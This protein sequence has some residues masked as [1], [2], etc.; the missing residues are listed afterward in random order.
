[1]TNATAPELTSLDKYD[2][3]GF[4]T[5]PGPAVLL[6]VSGEPPAEI[7]PAAQDAIRKVRNLS[8]APACIRDLTLLELDYAFTNLSYFVSR[9]GDYR[10]K[11]MTL[12]DW[13]ARP[14]SPKTFYAIEVFGEDAPATPD[15]EG[16]VIAVLADH[17]ICAQSREPVELKN[18]PRAQ[19]RI[20]QVFAVSKMSDVRWS[21]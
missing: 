6:A 15:A 13:A 20:G 10:A 19:H 21:A 11:P 17:A 5:A 9:V 12:Q 4:A 1:M 18:Y 3:L 16:E 2:D 14:R 8:D 7:L